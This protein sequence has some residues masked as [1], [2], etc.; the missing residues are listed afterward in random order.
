VARLTS[1]P[2]DV[3]DVLVMMPPAVMAS[4]LAGESQE[5][6]DGKQNNE[7]DADAEHHGLAQ[8]CAQ[9][10]RDHVTDDGNGKATRAGITAGHGKV[11]GSPTDGGHGR[12][13]KQNPEPDEFPVWVEIDADQGDNKNDETCADAN[14]GFGRVLSETIH[15]FRKGLRIRAGG[16]CEH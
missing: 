11:R 12:E 14:R 15:G 4:V 5:E 16:C 7:Q 6:N 8:R 10:A 3:G 9:N 1:L 2:F 13:Q